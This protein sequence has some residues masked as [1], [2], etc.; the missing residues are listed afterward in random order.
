MPSQLKRD[1][2]DVLANRL[3]IVPI[4][5]FSLWLGPLLLFWGQAFG[6]LRP[7]HVSPVSTPALPWLCAS[8]V[9][10]AAVLLLPSGWYRVQRFEASGRIYSLL[11]AQVFRRF[12]SNGDYVNRLVS[13]RH[14]NY[15]VHPHA[16]RIEASS[17]VSLSSERSH[18]V[19]LMVGVS[20]F[21]YA[22]L[23]GWTGWAAWLA[24][25]NIFCNF[26]PALVQ[27]STRARLFRIQERLDRG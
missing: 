9:S 3:N 12:V 2:A 27:R 6:P 13:R 1:S 20:P 18:L 16:V 23:V 26:Y 22:L 24:M 19:A 15:R 11:G 4:A 17:K 25:T 8:I 14:P 7:F 5:L 21:V 10:G